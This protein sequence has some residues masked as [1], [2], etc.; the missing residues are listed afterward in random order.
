[1]YKQLFKQT[2]PIIGSV[3]YNAMHKLGEIFITT[4]NEWIDALFKVNLSYYID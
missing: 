4:L 2:L 3:V 1:M